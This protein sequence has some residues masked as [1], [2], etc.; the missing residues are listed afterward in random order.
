MARRRHVA[1][2]GEL[3]LRSGAAAEI[4][5]LLLAKLRYAA[6]EI[7]AVLLAKLHCTA[8]GIVALL[9]SSDYRSARR[10]ERDPL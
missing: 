4:V 8:A 5:D 10:N 6:A 7:V 9:R 3:L 1:P 2:F